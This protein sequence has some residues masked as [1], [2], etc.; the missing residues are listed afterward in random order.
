[1]STQHNN[2]RSSNATTPSA[3]IRRA[4]VAAIVLV[5]V[6]IVVSLG[7]GWWHA[8]HADTHP[9]VP[10]TPGTATRPLAPMAATAL[11]VQQLQGTWL[12]PDGGYIIDVRTV[13]EGG[14]MDVAYCNPRPINVSK[15]EAS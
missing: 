15:A 13:A 7:C 12:R 14:T 5:A 3:G 8:E 2:T 9:T 1:M 4:P 6:A 11:G 10:S